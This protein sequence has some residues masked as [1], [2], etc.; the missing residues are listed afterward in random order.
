MYIPR[1]V[2]QVVKPDPII[3]YGKLRP[4]LKKVLVAP[5]FGVCTT[6]IIAF[7]GYANI[8]SEYIV[9]FFKS[10]YTD[11]YVNTITHGMSMPRLGTENAR[12][13]VFPLPPLSEQYRI[14]E[15]IRLLL[16]I[17]DQLE[18]QLLKKKEIIELLGTA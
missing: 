5:S 18:F 8:S 16:S 12:E 6:E 17:I 14:V 13:L 3:Y 2:C 15:R 1:S 4:Y 7:R 10:K 11:N 9:S